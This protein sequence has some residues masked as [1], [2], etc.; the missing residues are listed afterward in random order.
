MYLL[1]EDNRI[2]L[3]I[4]A[5][6]VSCKS[7]ATIQTLCS[8]LS[9]MIV[10][11]SKGFMLKMKT[12]YGHFPINIAIEKRGKLVEI[13][14]FLGEKNVRRIKMLDGITCEK[15]N[16]LKDEI[17]LSGN[18]IELLTRSAALISQS[19]I[20]KN[21]DIRKFLDGIYVSEKS[22]KDTQY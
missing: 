17:V 12:V 2:T 14:N 22:I 10:G 5:H 4:D 21:K 20:V 8:H 19:C 6:L 18:D 15:S 1:K 9:N 11:V 13:R 3:M 7:V 16:I